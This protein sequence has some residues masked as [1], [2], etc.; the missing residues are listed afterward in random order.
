MNLAL[1]PTE[2][3]V[4]Q[5]L[6]AAEDPLSCAQI[7]A[8]APKDRLWKDRSIYGIMKVLQQEKHVV[9]ETGAVKNELG[10]YVTVYKSAVSSDE[11][12]AQSFSALKQK[13]LP[14]LFSEDKGTVLLSL[15]ECSAQ[16]LLC[17]LGPGGPSPC[18]DFYPLCRI[19]WTGNWGF[20]NRLTVLPS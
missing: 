10:K 4:M 3:Q 18:L 11:Y 20:R 14:L 19:N 7:T 5:V 16:A 9:R 8:R 17:Y 1:T 15:S 12:Y 6:W 2:L 13:D